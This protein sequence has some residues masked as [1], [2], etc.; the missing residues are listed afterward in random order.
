MNAPHPFFAVRHPAYG[1][2]VFRSYSQVVAYD[3]PHPKGLYTKRKDA[4][5]RTLGEDRGHY[6]YWMGDVKIKKEELS[7][8]E[9]SLTM[10]VRRVD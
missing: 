4:E 3:Y 10:D 2:L 9:V 8:V 5:F 6:S 7:I 1:Y